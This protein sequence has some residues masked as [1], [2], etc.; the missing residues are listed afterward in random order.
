MGVHPRTC[1]KDQAEV[2]RR[3]FREG[4]SPHMREGR[5]APKHLIIDKGCIPAHAGRTLVFKCLVFQLFTRHGPYGVSR[6]DRT[7]RW[8]V[9]FR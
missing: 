4:A 2:V 3:I 9:P 8:P 7:R 5:F 6:E 1:G